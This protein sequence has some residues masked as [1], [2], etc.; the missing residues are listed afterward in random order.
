MPNKLRHRPIGNIIHPLA[1]LGVAVAGEFLVK[2]VVSFKWVKLG[3]NRNHTTRS[4][5]K[6]RILTSE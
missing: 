2:S 3:A 5:C 6:L 1:G 4:E